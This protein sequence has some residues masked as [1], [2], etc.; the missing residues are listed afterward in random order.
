M[1][2]FA[3]LLLTFAETR[4]LMFVAGA[5]NGIGFG[6]AHNALFALAFDRVPITQ[7]GGATA[8]FRSAWDSGGIL[9]GIL[10]GLLVFSFGVD[11]AFWASSGILIC[12]VLL[13]LFGVMAGMT[14]SFEMKET[15]R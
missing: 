1:L 3:M 11:A 8:L 9:G 12:A 14:E 13:Y 2:A 15:E 10:L 6:M 7:R 4:T 5:I